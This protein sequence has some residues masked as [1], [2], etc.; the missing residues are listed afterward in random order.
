MKQLSKQW[1]ILLS[2]AALAP[3]GCGSEQEN[4]DIPGNCLLTS[5]SS[6]LASSSTSG[7]SGGSSGSMGGPE[8]CTNGLDDDGDDA[9]DCADTECVD[10][11]TC[12]P[13][14]PAGFTEIVTITVT[15]YGEPTA[16]CAG[17]ITAKPYYQNPAVDACDACT[18]DA[19]GV[20]CTP[21][22]IATGFDFGMTCMNLQPTQ[23]SPDQCQQV[24]GTASLL[25]AVM[26]A[27]TCQATTSTGTPKPPMETVIATC[28]LGGADGK[29]CGMSGACVSSDGL[30]TA[31]HL[32]IKRPGHE[33]CPAD[34]P[35]ALYAFE[36]FTDDRSGCTPCGCSAKC[37]G[38]DYMIFPNDNTCTTTGMPVDT[39]GTCV[40]AGDSFVG[41]LKM[42]AL[43]ASC[44]TTGGS[45]MGTVTPMNETTFCCF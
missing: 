36:S 23:L 40:S 45:M 1:W 3:N 29:G 7:S 9:I 31:E 19:S 4:C 21:G 38:G 18:C 28:S 2:L 30:A 17:G 37:E 33:V 43:T 5:G 6:G 32:C 24:V 14:I 39:V 16:A 42:S 15:P 35:L 8:D 13:P 34:W 22:Q 44:T 11:Y 12:V 10:K 25:S 41:G 26:T 20:L 27:G